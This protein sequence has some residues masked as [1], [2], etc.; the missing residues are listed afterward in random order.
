[1]KKSKKVQKIETPRFPEEMLLVEKAVKNIED[2][3]QIFASIFT[4]CT[5]DAEIAEN[6]CLK[7]TIIKNTTFHDTAF[8]RADIEDARF[9][10]CDLSNMDFSNASFNRVEFIDCKLLGANFGESSLRSVSIC[11]C[12]A[13]YANFRF[14]HWNGVNIEESALCFTDFQF[15]RFIAVRL[16]NTDLREGQLS[17]TKLDGIDLSTCNISG[18][19]VRIEDLK[20]VAVSPVQAVMLSG[21]MGVVVQE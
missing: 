7:E 11:R 13:G 21:L 10:N 20:G 6:V 17:G 9:E 4:D 1:M 15:S 12:N 16:M 14:S 3:Q 18:L 5:F 2:E 19:G 8:R